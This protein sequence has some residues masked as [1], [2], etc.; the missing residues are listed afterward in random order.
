MRWRCAPVPTGTLPGDLSRPRFIL[1]LVRRAARTAFVDARRDDSVPISMVGC[2]G[3]RRPVTT[4]A[5]RM[6]TA[7]PPARPRIVSRNADGRLSREIFRQ[8]DIRGIVGDDLTAEAAHA[9]GR[10][11]AALSARARASRARSPSAATTGRAATSCATRSCAG[12]PSAGVDVVD[13]GVVPTPLLYWALHHLAVVGRHPDHRLAQSARV[14][15]IQAVARH[16]VDAR[17]GDPAALSSSPI[18]ATVPAG[19]G[20]VRTRDGHRSRTSTTSSRASGKLARPIKVVVRLRQRRRRARRAAAVRRARRRTDAGCSARATARFP[21]HHPDP[22]VP[23]NLE[24]LIARRAAATAPSSASRSTATPTASASS[25]ATGSI[26]WGDHVLILYARDVLARTGAGPADHLRREVLAG[27]AATRSRRPA[28]VPVMWKT[29]HSLIKDKMKEL[30][31]PVA[32]EMSGHMFF[33]EGFYG[34]DDALY[35]AA[36]L[37]RIVADSGKIARRAARRRARVRLDAGAPRR[38]AEESRKFADRRRGGAR[39][40]A[41]R[42]R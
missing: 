30:H 32:G 27:A 23:E 40:S 12:S 37:L 19:K 26:V 21:N 11:Y 3:R 20:S 7:R 38:R 36:R 10:A 42:T 1:L 9:L 22:T 4:A 14:Q 17:R 16:G 5:D 41:R 6:T 24:D 25:T 15:R 8:Y 34:H 13:I 29:G 39:T 18:A 35:G 31:A 2:A 33:T 28:A